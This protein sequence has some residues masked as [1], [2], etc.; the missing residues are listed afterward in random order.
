MYTNRATPAH[1]TDINIA[2]RS[3]ATERMQEWRDSAL[4]PCCDNMSACGVENNTLRV[5]CNNT[6][7]D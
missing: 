4:R 1:A 6:M 2:R 3:R 7:S 5:Y